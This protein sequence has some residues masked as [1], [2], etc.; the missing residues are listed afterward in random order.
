MNKRFLADLLERAGRSFVQGFLGLW[1]ANPSE[2][3]EFDTL[4]TVDNLKAGVVMATLS[5]GMALLGKGVGSPDT[6]SVLPASVAP[7]PVEP[8][9]PLPATDM[10][11]PPPNVVQVV[12]PPI[13]TTAYSA[14]TGTW[15]TVYL[16]PA[17]AGQGR[18]SLTGAEHNGL[19]VV[20]ERDGGLLAPI[21]P[22]EQATMGL[23]HA[24]AH[25]D[26]DG[27]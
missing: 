26:G 12:A 2:P 4:F 8:P 6:A 9:A 5:V 17:P 21:G 23:R 20:V 3:V 18:F 1:L 27:N 19:P 15:V 25:P 24:A 13:V 22:E 10:T 7:P 11:L 16:R 14:R